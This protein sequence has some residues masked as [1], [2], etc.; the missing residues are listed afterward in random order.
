MPQFGNEIG[1]DHLPAAGFR[2]PNPIMSLTILQ[3][4]AADLLCH[5]FGPTARAAQDT[6]CKQSDGACPLPRC[7]TAAPELA[8]L[9]QLA[10]DGIDDNCHT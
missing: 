4:G 6:A 9:L 2:A 10:Y 3:V 1:G 7:C 5:N 8:P